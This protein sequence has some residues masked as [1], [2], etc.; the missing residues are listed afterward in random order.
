[1]INHFKIIVSFFLIIIFS[2]CV[3]INNYKTVKY[4]NIEKFMGDWYVIANIPTFI[5]KQAINP[6]ETYLLNPDGYI[7]TKF[8]FYKNSF[9]EIKTY[10]AKGFI[11]NLDTNAEWKMQFFWPVK[12]PYLIIDIADDYSFTVISVPNKKYIWIMSRKSVLDD[13]IYNNILKKLDQNGYD[14]SKIKKTIQILD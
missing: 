2:S 1:M 8:S 3:N 9:K 11:K 7:D 12:F 4:I 5:E 6:I 14:I 10:R 13:H